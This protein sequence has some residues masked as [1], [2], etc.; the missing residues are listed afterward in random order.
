MAM[1]RE[2][3]QG[4]GVSSRG[5]QRSPEELAAVL[6]RLADQ[7][8]DPEPRERSGGGRRRS[9]SPLRP[10]IRCPHAGSP[11]VAPAR[12]ADKPAPRRAKPPEARVPSR[13]RSSRSRR[14]S[15]TR[16]VPT[17]PEPPATQG[18]AREATSRH[19]AR[20]ASQARAA[21]PAR[22]GRQVPGHRQRPDRRHPDQPRRPDRGHRRPTAAPPAAPEPSQSAGRRAFRRCAEG[23]GPGGVAS[24]RRTSAPQPCVR[25]DQEPG[26]R[27]T[28]AADV[29]PSQ[30]AHVGDHP[31]RA[32]PARDRAL[33]AH[34]RGGSG[35]RAAARL[36]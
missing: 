27:P 12:V 35:D 18:P 16:P 14:R 2:A 25:P 20:A 1:S 33:G 5:R 32:G 6:A 21:P 31:R 29:D 13:R 3:G 24:H 8:G 23:T 30:W 34:E 22:A 9:G 11:P 17:K 28:P 4:R 19:R 15:S 7:A 10:A 36:R 26:R